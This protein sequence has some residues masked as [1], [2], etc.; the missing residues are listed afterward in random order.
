MI[1]EI[2]KAD[3][4]AREEIQARS[5]FR[6]LVEQKAMD[7]ETGTIAGTQ[8]SMSE[9]NAAATATV[10]TT[11]DAAMC[12][13]NQM[14]YS[15]ITQIADRGL[16]LASNGVE[17]R[18]LLTADEGESLAES[19]LYDAQILQIQLSCPAGD[20]ILCHGLAGS[21]ITH[22]QG[23]HHVRSWSISSTTSVKHARAHRSCL[24]DTRQGESYSH[25]HTNRR[26]FRDGLA[27]WHC[28]SRVL[29]WRKGYGYGRRLRSRS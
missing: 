8:A 4:F 19:V 2:N 16:Q 26:Q 15:S 18:S 7:L 25:S 11:S 10:V 6:T 12:T 3:E 5:R 29:G 27:P 21:Q 17:D 22:A 24:R 14:N 20:T 13:C 28:R 1:D 9:S 23:G